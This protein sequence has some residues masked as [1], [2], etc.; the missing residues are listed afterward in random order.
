[1]G[2][3]RRGTLVLTRKGLGSETREV[4]IKKSVTTVES[5]SFKVSYEVAANI[6]LP[7]SRKKES[8]SDLA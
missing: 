4:K 7:A 5:S 2:Q 3:K 6:S 1:M 8:F